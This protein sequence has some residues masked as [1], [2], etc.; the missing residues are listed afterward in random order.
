MLVIESDGMDFES[1]AEDF[2]KIVNKIDAELF[3]LFS[4]ENFG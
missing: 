2:R 4:A 1:N 3:G